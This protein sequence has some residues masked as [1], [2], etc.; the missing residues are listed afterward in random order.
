MV[1][2]E[3]S[4]ELICIQGGHNLVADMLLR[5]DLLPEREKPAANTLLAFDKDDVPS[6]CFP[7][8]F[9]RIAQ[10]QR[11]DK[12]L[13]DRLKTDS[14]LNLKQFHGGGK[15]HELIVH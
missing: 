7:V 15:M 14:N 3:C 11:K 9:K 13:L 6:D 1:L 8:R 4:P 5:L 12:K 2:E 10:H